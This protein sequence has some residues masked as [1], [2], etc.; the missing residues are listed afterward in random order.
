MEGTKVL[1]LINLCCW[2]ALELPVVLGEPIGTD[3]EHAEGGV[4]A[5]VGGIH[6]ADSII[7][8]LYL[9]LLAQVENFFDYHKTTWTGRRAG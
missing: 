4:A 9:T 5:L 6:R 7:G 1:D 8:L 3:L 2:K